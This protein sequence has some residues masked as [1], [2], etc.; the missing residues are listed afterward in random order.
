MLTILQDHFGR[1]VAEAKKYIPEMIGESGNPQRLKLKMSGAKDEPPQQKIMLRM[2]GTR[3]DSPNV[4]PRPNSASPAIHV[5]GSSA[6]INDDSSRPRRGENVRT[7]SMSNGI[8]GSRNPFSGGHTGANSITLL[9]QTS[10]DRTGSFSGSAASPSPSASAVKAEDRS[11]QS[12]SAALGIDS[13][14][15]AHTNGVPPAIHAPGMPPPSHATQKLNTESPFL[16]QATP[17]AATVPLQAPQHPLVHTFESKWRLPGRGKSSH[18]ND[19]FSE[20]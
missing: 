11:V 6:A 20:N 14:S 1:R 2:G 10:K 5:N 12:P 18:D 13:P 8:S 17:V 19:H 3:K 9:S 7:S 4:T 16:A 15:R